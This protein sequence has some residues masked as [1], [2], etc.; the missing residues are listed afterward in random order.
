MRKST[1]LKFNLI[2]ILFTLLVTTIVIFTWEKMLRAPTFTWLDARYSWNSN[3]ERWDYEQR[4]EH[5]IISTL[6]DV[7]VVTL[8]LRLVSRQQRKLRASEGRYRS[9]FEHAVTGIAILGA[10]DH[11]LIDVNHKFGSILGYQPDELL[12]KEIDELGWR[13]SDNPAPVGLFKSLNGSLAGEKEL[14]VKTASGSE[15]P[16]SVSS[17]PLSIDDENFII[18]LVQDISRRKRLEMEKE[19]MQRLLFQSAKLTSLGELSAGVAHEI[20]NPLNG[21]INFAQ[22]L[23]DDLST[24]TETQQMMLDNIIGEGERISEIVRNLLTF[25]RQDSTA[26]ARVD[27]AGTIMA[28]LSLFSHQLHKDGIEVRVDVPDDL[29]PVL[30]DK[31]RLRQV[32]VNMISNAHYA[33]KAASSGEE[34]L[35]FITGRASGAGAEQKVRIEFFD[36]GIGMSQE[37]IDKVFNPF[38]TTKR[39]DGGTGLGLSLSFGIVRAHQGNITVESVE[40]SHTRFIIELPAVCA[41]NVEEIQRKAVA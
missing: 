19:Q 6:V 41:Q 25:A 26:L 40:S 34:R 10:A 16:V 18:L 9:L 36:N 17:N 39:D 20:N 29:P 8:L 7:I 30:A 21:I 37:V 27:I 15:V 24:L 12:G 28:S 31:S 4:V 23:K 33:L 13:V 38:F 5:Y 2:F 1:N 3:D 35:L 14:L 32:M 11:R 22:L